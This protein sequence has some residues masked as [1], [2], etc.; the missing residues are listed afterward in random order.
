V[1]WVS[2]VVLL[3]VAVD[4]VRWEEADSEYPESTLALLDQRSWCGA[5]IVPPRREEG[6]DAVLAALLLLLGAGPRTRMLGIAM[7]S[8]GEE[9]AVVAS[10]K[11]VVG[12]SG[13]REAAA[14][15]YW[16]LLR[17]EELRSV[18]VV[19]EPRVEVLEEW[20]GKVDWEGRG[21]LRSGRICAQ[22]SRKRSHRS[23]Q[24]CTAEPRSSSSAARP[25]RLDCRR[26][27]SISARDQ[28]ARSKASVSCGKEVGS[29]TS[30]W[31]SVM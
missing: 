26:L 10:S 8:V 7:L 17:L 21:V 2:S 19:L 6:L 5:E 27:K 4:E 22:P 23:Q 25:S 30:R 3:A 11:I 29:L 16:R 20:K 15:W 28:Q 14:S 31:Q 9:V 24:D 18:A 13:G 12:V 1:R